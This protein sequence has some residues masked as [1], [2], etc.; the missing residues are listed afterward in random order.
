MLALIV[1]QLVSEC[2]SLK[3]GSLAQS[4]VSGKKQYYCQFSETK[5]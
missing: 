2:G 4:R 3:N 1:R 5:L